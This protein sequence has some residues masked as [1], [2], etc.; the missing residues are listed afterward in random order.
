[1]KIRLFL[2]LAFAAFLGACSS[3][4][5]KETDYINTFYSNV[6]PKLIL[7]SLPANADSALWAFAQAN[8]KNK[9]SDTF[10]YQAIQIKLARNMTLQAAQWA[11][12]YLETF[13]KSQNH[14]VDLY[15]MAAHHYEQHQVFDRALEL[16]K[17]FINEFPNHEIAPQAKQMVEFIEKGLV[18]PEQ[19]LEYLL[20]KK[21]PQS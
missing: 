17:N 6:S 16:Y 12:V 19:Q 8:P 15:V 9:Q 7:D 2:G 21:L 20:N 18:T 4:V 13:K 14:R 10:A 11:E 3:N 1:M 5:D